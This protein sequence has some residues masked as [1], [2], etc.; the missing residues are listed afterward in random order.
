[1]WRSVAICAP[2]YPP[3]EALPGR[4]GTSLAGRREEARPRYIRDSAEDSCSTP[5]APEAEGRTCPV[6]QQHFD[7]PG[8][9]GEGGPVERRFPEVVLAGRVAPLGASASPGGSWLL[10]RWVWGGLDAWLRHSSR[11][12]AR[13]DVPDN[14]R[15]P[16]V[17]APRLSQENFTF[18]VLM[19][20][21]R[22]SLLQ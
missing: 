5:S 22:H 13:L 16:E 11:R 15:L 14:S 8:L 6:P 2:G 1:M 3:F 10:H 21:W 9:A 18:E 19:A 4:I 17:V 7:G 20:R 12:I